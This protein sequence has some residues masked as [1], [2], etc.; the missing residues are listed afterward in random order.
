MGSSGR[1]SIR[2]RLGRF[3][4]PK[5]LEWLV[6]AIQDDD[7][8]LLEA[9]LELSRRRRLFAPLALIVGA[10][11]MLIQGVRLLLSN[12]RLTLVQVLPA[13]WIWLAMFD[14]RAHV[15]HGKSFHALRGPILIPIGFAIV[16]ITVATFFLDAAFA[17]AIAGEPPPRVR[18]AFLAARE[19]IVP[20]AIAGVLLGVPLALATTVA[21]RYGAPWFTLSLGVVVGAMMVTYVAV[22][23]RL[24]GVRPTY[25]RR[26]KLAVSAIS[27]GL[28]VTI[29]TPPYLVARIGILMLGSRVLF[30]PGIFV[31]TFGVTL[32]AGA[33]GAV[34][35]IKMSARLAAGKDGEDGAGDPAEPSESSAQ[36][37]QL[38]G[39]DGEEDAPNDQHDA[40][41]HRERRE[42][43]FRPREDQHTT[44][45]LQ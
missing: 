20:I 8:V 12:W 37:P 44:D 17:F 7:P 28:S 30:I 11:A 6:R 22:P 14:L 18:P 5:R 40:H 2:A 34:R 35:A 21:T 16:A 29:C 33:T 45:H 36:R 15:L 42:P 26:D 3:S 41:D 10:F 27:A 1:M 13:V 23:S 9:V 32:Q 31:L 25:T 43:D 39:G 38:P 19:R 4:L 24:I